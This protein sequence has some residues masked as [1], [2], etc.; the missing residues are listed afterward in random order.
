MTDSEKRFWEDLNWARTHHS[1]LLARYGDEWIA[2]YNKQV[3]AHS[4]SGEKVE[5]LARQKLGDEKFPVYFV[6]SASNIY[7][8]QPLLHCIQKR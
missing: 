4:P 3:I 6:D 7:A 5:K 1:Q 8:G 2:V